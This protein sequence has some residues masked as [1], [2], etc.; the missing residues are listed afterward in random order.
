MQ[1]SVDKK[2][3]KKAKALKSRWSQIHAVSDRH[4]LVQ[5]LLATGASAQTRNFELQRLLRKVV[6]VRDFV[7]CFDNGLRVDDNLLFPVDRD[8]LSGTVWRAAVIDQ[9]T[10][11]DEDP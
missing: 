5:V 3:K 1:Q 8:D 2:A 9:A 7:S 4:S 11:N 10:A 6:V